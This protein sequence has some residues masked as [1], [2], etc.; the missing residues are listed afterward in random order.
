MKFLQQIYH[1]TVSWFYLFLQLGRVHSLKRRVGR[2]KS[3]AEPQSV[4]CVSFTDLVCLLLQAPP[5]P[6]TTSQSRCALWGHGCSPAPWRRSLSW[7]VDHKCRTRSLSKCD[8]LSPSAL[9]FLLP[10]TQNKHQVEPDVFVLKGG[11]T[12]HNLATEFIFNNWAQRLRPE[13]ST[14]WLLQVSRPDPSRERVSRLP[15]ATASDAGSR[16]PR[17]L[18]T[19]PGSVLVFGTDSKLPS[20][21]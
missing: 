16:S 4:L 20:A 3:W 8:L 13:S 5:A 7:E 17:T 15:E 12:D 2:G 11:S 9:F 1:L 14:N 6:T 10:K 18:Q 21:K 19:G